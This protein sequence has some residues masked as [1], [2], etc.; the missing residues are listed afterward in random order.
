M[1]L[2][3][4]R[5]VLNTYVPGH[6]ELKMYRW[7]YCEANIATFSPLKMANRLESLECSKNDFTD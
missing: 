3:V 4:V 1:R 5:F 2:Y 7:L 6:P